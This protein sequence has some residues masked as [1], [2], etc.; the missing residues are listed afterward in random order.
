FR[1][2]VVLG[3][4]SRHLNKRLGPCRQS[5]APLPYRPK[6]AL[7]RLAADRHANQMTGTQVGADR[8]AAQHR[9]ANTFDRCLA[10]SKVTVEFHKRLWAYPTNKKVEECLSPGAFFT[11]N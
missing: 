4:I 9:W 2:I 7:Q 5:S 11:L 1:L 10:N 3:T 8:Q 6:G